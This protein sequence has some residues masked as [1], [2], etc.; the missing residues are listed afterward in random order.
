MI[1]FS[2]FSP[3]T[4]ELIYDVP[5]YEKN[6]VDSIC[7]QAFDAFPKWRK[8]SL[9][10][11]KI[12]LQKFL[13]N[14]QRN[15]KKIVDC[16]IRD[17]GKAECEAVTEVIES[18]DII[19]FYCTEEFEG[20]DKSQFIKIDD[21]MWPDKMA[22]I[23]YEP[24][25]VFAVIKPW[26]YPFEMPIWAIAPLLLTGNTIVFKPS[27][28][29]NAT[30]LLLAELINSTGIPDGVF[31][32]L[33]GNSQTG[34]FLV[35][36]KRVVGISF[37]G[38]TGVGKKIAASK[39][40]CS[41]LSLE[42]GGSDFAVVLKDADWDIAISGLLWGAFTNAGQVCVATEKIIIEEGIYEGFVKNLVEK[43]SQLVMA[44]DISP[45]IS[46]TQLKRAEHIVEIAVENGCK[47]LYGGRK[48]KEAGL[49]CGNYFMPTI[50]ECKDLNFLKRLPELF[51]PIVFV[52]PF[53]SEEEALQIVNNNIYGLGC[54]IWTKV[55]EK[56]DR[57]I[58]NVE[59]GMIWINEVNLPMPQIPWTGRKDSA[60]GL[61]LSKAAVY[62]AMDMKIIH[63]DKSKC[64]R[65]W[66]YPYN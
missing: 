17:T 57:L 51:A 48:V 58:L 19:N 59:S 9:E 2:K 61:N 38:S 31:N 47:V 11:R 54:S 40:M 14:I 49:E 7:E 26:N 18:C 13:E 36:N 3:K 42:M 33:Q 8:S 12:V 66:W 37:T 32:I 55:P 44:K 15:Q 45:I 21:Q 4:N 10:Q 16:I 34:E 39:Q 1:S 60:I 28:L 29:S 46:I 35:N 62:E 22:C 56:H 23:V 5:V 6:Q 27:E 41:K 50:I 63:I 65:E 64:G 20:I 24:C 53:T 43:T 52:T 30:G 25:G